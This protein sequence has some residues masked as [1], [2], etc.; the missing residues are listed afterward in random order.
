MRP[1]LL[2][3][4]VLAPAQSPNVPPPTGRLQIWPNGRSFEIRGLRAV[5]IGSQERF[6]LTTGMRIDEIR[7]QVATV[8]WAELSDRLGE[9]ARL[10]QATR[11]RSNGP[12]EFIALRVNR[13][14]PKGVA[15]QI[16][17][18]VQPV[19]YT[20]AG[21]IRQMSVAY[22]DGRV[23]RSSEDRVQLQYAARAGP[24]VLEIVAERLERARPY[25]R[26]SYRW[27]DPMLHP[28]RLPPPATQPTATRPASTTQPVR[29]PTRSAGS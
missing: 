27:E 15:Y 26:I 6:V 19:Q 8:P 16:Q 22:G 5:A 3:A 21:L 7:E 20:S 25:W 9:P 11:V 14:G 10:L 13:T 23:V 1:I 4:L 18:V 17:Y 2:A 28:S 12:T 29:P 24:V